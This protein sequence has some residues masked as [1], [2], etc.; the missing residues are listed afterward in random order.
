[1]NS[2]NNIIFFQF[3][4]K[5]R[6]TEIKNISF[7]CQNFSSEN[8]TYVYLFEQSFTELV[9][10][11]FKLFKARAS[12]EKAWLDFKFFKSKPR[13]AFDCKKTVKDPL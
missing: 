1:M 2:A 3:L 5:K 7:R 6:E 12:Y 4:P 13:R 8:N 11:V 9:R 10:Q